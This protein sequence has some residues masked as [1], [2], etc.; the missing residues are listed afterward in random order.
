M[1]SDRVCS[2]NAAS[3]ARRRARDTADAIGARSAAGGS[4]AV[5]AG[6][7]VVLS[8]PDSGRM[9]FL[10]LTSAPRPLAQLL[11][12]PG[13]GGMA[14]AGTEAGRLCALLAALWLAAGGSSVRGACSALKFPSAVV[15]TSPVSRFRIWRCSSPV[16]KCWMPCAE[17]SGEKPEASPRSPRYSDL[18]RLDL[19]MSSRTPRSPSRVTRTN[20]RIPALRCPWRRK[21]LCVLL[22]RLRV[23]TL[24]VRSH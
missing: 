12:L 15:W 11:L 20:G 4:A 22:L 16:S 8:N 9:R 1:Y 14:N 7:E 23:R 10:G 2:D 6:A 3:L 24:L 19:E 18:S 5:E 17:R 13:G 21:Y